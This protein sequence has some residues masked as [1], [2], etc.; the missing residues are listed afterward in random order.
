MSY[1]YFDTNMEAAGIHSVEF[2]FLL[3][4]L[5]VAGL[6]ALAKRFDTPYPIILVIGGLILSFFPRI[7]HVALNPDIVFLVILPPLLFSSAFVTSWREFRYNLISITMLALGLV[8]F[9]VRGVAYFSHWILP[10]FDFRLGLVLGAVV[11]T[12]D[13]IAATSIAQRIGLPKRIT[14]VIE[15]ES[16]VNDASGLLA[17]EFAVAFVLSGHIPGIAVRSER[18]AFIILSSIAIGLVVGKVINYF[19]S[20]IEDASIEITISLIAPYIAYLSGESA[21]SSGVLS[22][23]VCGLYLGHKSSLYLSIGARLRGSAVWE[24]LTFILNGF[25]FILLGLQ[26]PY[27]LEGIHEYTIGRLL[28]LG[29]EFSGFVIFL[30]LVWVYPGAWFSNLIRRRL[31][32]QPERL[33]DPG[34]IF[35]IGWTGMRG[36]VALAAAISLP[37]FL[38]DGSPFPQR[39]L[40]IFLTFS[41]IFVTLVLQGLTLPPLIRWLGLADADGE[42]KE[43]TQARRA[44]VQAALAYLESARE[45]EGPEIEPVY[46]ELIRLQRQRL[47]LLDAKASGDPGRDPEHYDRYLA[48]SQHLRSLQRATILNLRNHNRI[49]DET[50][51]KLEYELDLL[52]TR[53]ART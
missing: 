10:G 50:L 4:L 38:N 12:T 41:V 23:V 14:A 30:R 45:S 6:A 36:V 9:T 48:I 49:N 8:L 35:I 20:K 16:L 21:H 39:N 3:L 43:E 44:M 33:A 22:T 1:L 24:T 19:E 51:R 42:N 2:I 17:L 40:I 26:L 28:I 37:E 15:G 5:F 7:P 11:C 29:A 46:D 25:V 18:L 53:Y 13:A 47:S 34:S 32:H 27:V 31:L 52:D